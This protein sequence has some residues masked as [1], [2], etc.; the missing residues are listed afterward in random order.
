MS[1]GAHPGYGPWQSPDLPPDYWLRNPKIAPLPEWYERPRQCLI[2]KDDAISFSQARAILER[3]WN[4]TT[5]EIRLWLAIGHPGLHAFDGRREVWEPADIG[6][7]VDGIEWGFWRCKPGLPG[8][9]RPCVDGH[10]TGVGVDLIYG[11][12]D[13]P[14]S[15]VLVWYKFSKSEV[16]AFDPAKNDDDA[17]AP[18]EYPH[19]RR[20]N[21]SGRL[22]T[23]AQAV[24]FMAQCATHEEAV[25]V[26]KRE[27]LRYALFG[28]A[29]R[30]YVWQNVTGNLSDDELEQAPMAEMWFFEGQIVGLAKH[31]FVADVRRWDAASRPDATEEVLLTESDAPVW[32]PERAQATAKR[33]R[34]TRLKAAEVAGRNALLRRLGREPSGEEFFQ[35]LANEDKTGAI[36]DQ[37]SDALVWEDQRGNSHK[38]KFT[39]IATTLSR[40]RN[41]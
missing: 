24:A 2:E 28:L 19:E 14:D 8:S 25:A 1:T 12:P 27:F 4:A 37:E 41:T 13:A 22:L 32:G 34:T 33:T 26:L 7:G 35:Y 31:E 29:P 36:I 6:D 17:S 10:G 15:E 16:E 9:T 20:F 38:V 39:T 5:T 30:G 3:K 11:T 40:L 23:H 18:I 21:P